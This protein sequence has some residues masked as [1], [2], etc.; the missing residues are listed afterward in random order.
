M[1]VHVGSHVEK[2][3]CWLLY[4]I[5]TSRRALWNS[6]QCRAQRVYI[7][8]L[9]K[10]TKDPSRCH[11][12]NSFLGHHFSK[13]PLN[14]GQGHAF[15]SPHLHPHFVCGLSHLSN[16]KLFQSAVQWSPPLKEEHEFVGMGVHHHWV[17]MTNIPVEKEMLFHPCC[18][19]KTP[20]GTWTLTV[21]SQVAT[22]CVLRTKTLKEPISSS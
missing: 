19:G 12:S 14:R 18:P 17:D 2:W 1:E 15:F 10:W 21:L 20:W 7:C 5:Q 6:I 4:Q 16:H 8:C 9:L 13:A 22:G 11:I 3:H